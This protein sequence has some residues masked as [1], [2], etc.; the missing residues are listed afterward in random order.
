[1][2]IQFHAL[3]SF[4][5]LES[6]VWL[7]GCVLES[8]A[9]GYSPHSCSPGHAALGGELSEVPL[10]PD[11]TQDHKRST[12]QVALVLCSLLTEVVDFGQRQGIL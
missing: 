8:T 2:K 12:L 5:V 11:S 3:D 4:R 7:V 6:H 10:R 9:L 1:M